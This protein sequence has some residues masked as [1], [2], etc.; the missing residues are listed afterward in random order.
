MSVVSVFMREYVNDRLSF[1]DRGSR[2]NYAEV[3]RRYERIIHDPNTSPRVSS[4][5]AIKFARFQV[6]VCVFLYV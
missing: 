6:R 4:F 5:Y 2:P 1:A 3:T